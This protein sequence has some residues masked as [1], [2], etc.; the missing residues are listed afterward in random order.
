MQ[1][2]KKKLLSVI[3]IYLNM[4]TALISV[5]VLFSVFLY[6]FQQ[7]RIKENPKYSLPS[8]LRITA[9]VFS[10][11]LFLS[12]LGLLLFS[13]L[14]FSKMKKR[15]EKIEKENKEEIEDMKKNLASE[16]QLTKIGSGANYTLKQKTNL[17]DI[18]K[19]M[20]LLYSP[21]MVL[22]VLCT[23]LVFVVVFSVSFLIGN[24]M[25]M[26]VFAIYLLVPLI[27]FMTFHYLIPK[28]EMKKE[29][30]EKEYTFLDDRLCI[31]DNQ[32]NKEQLFYREIE[33]SKKFKDGICLV[34]QNS[35]GKKSG[36]F[37]P[38][39][40]KNNPNLFEFLSLKILHREGLA[41]L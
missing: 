16:S 24:P 30:G 37:I 22:I 2:N 25:L 18:Q 35:L 5:I 39:D 1:S 17:S 4:M 32:S 29:S 9:L 10:V 12:L 11:I 41:D 26:L 38:I 6:Y 36:I 7:M 19:A 28:H 34:Y 23:V 3:P 21:F 13:L 14:H 31:Q 15:R 8:P 33:K 40:A 27:G 20:S